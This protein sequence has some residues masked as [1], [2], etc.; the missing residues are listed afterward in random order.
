MIRRIVLALILALGLA[1]GGGAFAQP[2]AKAAVDAAKAQGVVGEQGDGYLG[3]VGGATDASVKA[4]VDEINAGRSKAYQDIAART[5]VTPAAAG[6]A[7]ALQLAARL[8]SGYY[9]RPLGGSWTKK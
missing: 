5:G 6:E 7:T 4:A 9:F 2:S 1:G 3:F 8:P